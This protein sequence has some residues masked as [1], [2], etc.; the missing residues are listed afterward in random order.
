MNVLVI[1]LTMLAILVLAT[2]VVAYVAYPHR[3]HE[4]P[5]V[6]W[7]GRA[8]RRGVDAIPTLAEPEDGARHR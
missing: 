2:A 7:V 1:L 4:L 6:P 5:A 3:G 8:M